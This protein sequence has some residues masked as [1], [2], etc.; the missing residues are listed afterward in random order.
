MRHRASRV[1][2]QPAPVKLG[3]WRWLAYTGPVAV[4]MRGRLSLSFMRGLS[5]QSNDG[6]IEGNGDENKE[7]Y[8]FGT[9]ELKNF[10]TVFFIFSIEHADER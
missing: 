1:V 3:T 10:T 2:S 5:E 8:P 7:G 9:A 6:R 4:I